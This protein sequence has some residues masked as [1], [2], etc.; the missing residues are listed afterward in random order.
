MNLIPLFLDGI[1]AHMF[2]IYVRGIWSGKINDSLVLSRL[3][4]GSVN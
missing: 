1:I 4:R 2:V 3:S